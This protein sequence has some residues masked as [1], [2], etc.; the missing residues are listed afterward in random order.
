MSYSKRT[1]KSKV[2]L[3][4]LNPLIITI[5]NCFDKL[6]NLDFLSGCKN[7]LTQNNNES[8]HHVLWSF[9]SEDQYNGVIGVQSGCNIGICVFNSGFLK[10]FSAICEKLG[11][12]VT[13]GMKS[14][15][16]KKDST[17]IQ[18]NNRQ[19]L[20]T[21]KKRRKELNRNKKAKLDKFDYLEGPTYKSGHFCQTNSKSKGKKCAK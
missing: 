2:T 15:W 17:R 11:I 12:N 20:I 1:P 9:V 19:C 21:N 14:A 18:M 5:N 8:L 13:I 6:S 10:T 3:A 16:L 7:C 4:S